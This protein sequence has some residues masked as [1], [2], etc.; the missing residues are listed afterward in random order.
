MMVRK[1]RWGLSA[2]LVVALASAANAQVVRPIQLGKIFDYWVTTAGSSSVPLTLPP[3]FF[4]SGSDGQTVTVPLQGVP[5]GPGGG[6]GLPPTADTSIRRKADPSVSVPGDVGTTRIKFKGLSLGSVAPITVTYNG[7]SNPELWDVHIGLS[8]IANQ[9]WG[10]I[11]ATMTFDNGGNFDS[12]LPLV[13]KATFT[14]V[15]G[16]GT[17]VLDAGDP[18]WAIP[19]AT[20]QA[21]TI[22]W[23]AAL[24]GYTGS[25]HPG[26]DP[27]QAAR[28]AWYREY[29][30]NEDHEA[31]PCED[32]PDDG[33][34]GEVEPEPIGEQGAQPG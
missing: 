12:L 1:L 8:D 33:G 24:P 15:G 10:L 16:G 3:G 2:G 9:T 11:T 31:E 26:Y 4:G 30:Q 29:S 28:A 22:P 17:F 14:R 19:P 18:Q 23:V 21:F 7:G 34:G 25:F 13:W 32:C 6:Q 27:D 5:F 20:M